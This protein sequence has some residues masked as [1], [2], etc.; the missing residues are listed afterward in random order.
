MKKLHLVFN[1]VKLTSA[2]KDPIPDQYTAL[3]L[4]IIIVNEEWEVK[5]AQIADGT[6]KGIKW[7]GFGLEANSCKNISNVFVLDKVVEF[8]YLNPHILWFIWIA[9]LEQIKFRLVSLTLSHSNLEGRV[10]VRGPN[11][12]PY[13]SKQGSLTPNPVYFVL[14]F[15]PSN[16]AKLHC[17]AHR[18]CYK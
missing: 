13:L 8:Y 9:D 6:V 10:D 5:Q 17:K 18:V 11:F 3:H 12:S 2:L 14:D 16:T 7:K 4:D 15:L 1:I